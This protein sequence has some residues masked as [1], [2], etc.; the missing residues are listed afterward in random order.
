MANFKVTC[1]KSTRHKHFSVTAHITQEWQVNK[2]GE[3]VKVLQDCAEIT[4]RPDRNDLFICM[5]CGTTCTVTLPNNDLFI[6]P[7]RNKTLPS[8]PSVPLLE[9]TG[10][11]HH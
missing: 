4:H 7:Q 3:Y 9:R 5:T 6:R 8:I 11:I 10:Y 2:N 1:P